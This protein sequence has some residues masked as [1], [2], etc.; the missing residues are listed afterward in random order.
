MS[1]QPA[2]E[3][4]LEQDSF[5]IKQYHLEEEKPEYSFH[6]TSL[7]CV[8]KSIFRQNGKIDTKV[9]WRS[10]VKNYRYFVIKDKLSGWAVYDNPQCI[11]PLE[12]QFL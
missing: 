9:L 5:R 1:L 3:T 12:L 8:P 7:K 11:A 10:T 4:I 2:A 6:C